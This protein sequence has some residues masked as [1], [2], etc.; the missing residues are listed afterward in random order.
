MQN[1]PGSL[2]SAYF[3]AFGL[4]F[5]AELGDRTQIVSFSH[6]AQGKGLLSVI[7]GSSLALI[8]TSLISVALGSRLVMILPQKTLQRV[9]GGLFIITGLWI[10][11]RLLIP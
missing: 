2:L 5:L 7:I 1:K 4:V 9:S 11:F 3:T 6:A 10:W 8:A